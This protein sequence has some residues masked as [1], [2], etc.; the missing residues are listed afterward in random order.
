V[1]IYDLLDS[2][3]SGL[4]VNVFDTFDEFRDYTIGP[5][6]RQ[7]PLHKAK[8]DTFLPVFLKVLFPERDE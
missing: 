5:P 4:A 1:N 3:R 2:Q 7:Y 6:N 8:E